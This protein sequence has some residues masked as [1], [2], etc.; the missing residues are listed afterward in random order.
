MKIS[1]RTLSSLTGVF[2]LSLSLMAAEAPAVEWANLFDGTTSAG[3]QSSAILAVSG[4]AYWLNTLGS[5]ESAPDLFYAGEKIFTGS[6]YNGTSQNN[7][8]AL[9][10]TDSDGKAIW[11]IY[12]TSGDYA[13]N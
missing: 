7:N 3:D 12:S 2:G 4:G 9:T 8:F 5:T 13:A 10:K 6:L 1:T 11:T